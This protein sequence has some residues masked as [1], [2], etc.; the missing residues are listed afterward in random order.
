MLLKNIEYFVLF[1]HL[2]QNVFRSQ[3]GEKTLIK[4]EIE[5]L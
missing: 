2:C 4:V 5:V 1:F 3:S